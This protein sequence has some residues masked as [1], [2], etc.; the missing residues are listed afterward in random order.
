MENNT[1]KIGDEILYSKDR[2]SP[3]TVPG[4][5]TNLR[6]LDVY[7]DGDMNRYTGHIRRIDEITRSEKY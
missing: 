4:K 2:Q 7:I 6:H 3:P 1:I 5:I